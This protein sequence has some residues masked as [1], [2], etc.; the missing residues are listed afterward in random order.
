MKNVAKCKTKEPN[1]DNR[2]NVRRAGFSARHGG[3]ETHSYNSL[4]RQVFG[5][6]CF[7]MEYSIFD[8]RSAVFATLD[9]AWHRMP[10]NTLDVCLHRTRYSN[11]ER[12]IS[13]SARRKWRKVGELGEDVGRKDV[14]FVNCGAIEQPL[15]G[16]ALNYLAGTPHTV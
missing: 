5:N 3:T 1:A 13:A 7:A 14:F 16:A 4:D 8:V 11:S 2:R 9:G 10:C 6:P 12:L 15:I